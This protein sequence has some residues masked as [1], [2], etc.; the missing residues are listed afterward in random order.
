MDPISTAIIAATAK[1]AEPAIKDAYEALKSLLAKKFGSNSEVLQAVKKLE[2][3]SDSPARKEAVKEEVAS[4]K[5]NQDPELSKTAE[6][7]LSKLK[8]MPGGQQIVQQ[9]VSGEGHIFSGTG[10]VRV[11]RGK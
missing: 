2:E 4:V 9:T 6:A 10:D 11:D 5:A 1:L 8:G 7:L 3:K